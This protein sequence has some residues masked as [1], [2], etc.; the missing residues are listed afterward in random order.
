M[1]GV[2]GV[3]GVGDANED[4]RPPQNLYE[5]VAELNEKQR[6]DWARWRGKEYAIVP[7]TDAAGD[8]YCIG[9]FYEGIGCAHEWE[10]DQYVLP[11]CLLKLGPQLTR[12]RIGPVHIFNTSK[13]YHRLCHILPILGTGWKSRALRLNGDI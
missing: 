12:S 13:I 9:D 7:H 2:K 8:A 1:K 11:T 4:Y 6:A 3:K 5:A 10:I